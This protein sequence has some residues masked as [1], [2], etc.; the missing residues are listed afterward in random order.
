[1]EL[2]ELKYIIQ[3]AESGSL[4][5]AAANLFIAQSSLSSFLKKY[6]RNLGYKLFVR[7]PKGLIPTS[8]G[9][10]FLVYAKDMLERKR[11]LMNQLSDISNLKVG[12]IR[13]AISSYRSPY[14]LPTLLVEWKKLYPNIKIEIIEAHI[15]EH[16]ELLHKNAVDVCFLV[17]EKKDDDLAY[18][19]IIEEELLIGAHPSLG[20]K[21]KAYKKKGSDKW[22][23]SMNDIKDK[24]Y[25]LFSKKHS[26][27]IVT[28]SIFEENN[29]I[30][31]VELIQDNFVT[32][33]RLA[34]KGVGIVFVPHI[35]KPYHKNLE[36]YSIGNEG[37]YRTLA[38]GYPSSGYI[39]EATI[40]FSNLIEEIVLKK[41]NG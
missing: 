38:L 11:K 30:P 28:D 32:I 26:L 40:E 20:L 1:M 35:Y 4:T 33:L 41:S 39:S 36:Y 15:Y 18:R 9:E 3:L 21:E 37:S 23:I 19:N 25:L 8:E 13:F 34:E 22:R 5:K 6:E 27:K 16:K 12:N 31:R 14:L 2:R 29:I 24:P 17:N 10:V 7:T